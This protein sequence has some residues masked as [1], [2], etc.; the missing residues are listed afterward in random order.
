[1]AKR[2]TT[3]GKLER[4]RAKKAKQ[5]AKRE[6]RLEKGEENEGDDDAV[7]APSSSLSQDQVL[8]RL[9]ALHERFEAD[10]IDFEQF[11]EE[12]AALLTLLQLD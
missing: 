10:A 11:E 8:E 9:Q 5:A 4:D 7:A 3:F 12:K 2:G 6:R 1:M